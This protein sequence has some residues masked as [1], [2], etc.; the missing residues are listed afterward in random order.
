[1]S[2]YY[3]HNRVYF[4][5]AVLLCFT[6]CNGQVKTN[7]PAISL[8]SS[9]TIPI[10]Y[11]KPIKTHGSKQSDNIRCGLQDKAGNLWFGTTGD[12]VYR[13]DGKLFSNY[14]TKEGLSSNAV[15]S[16]IEDKTGNIW[17][18]TDA[19]L[20]SY[21]GKSFTSVPITSNN[22]FYPNNSLNSNASS[23]NQVWSILQDKSG[24]IWLGTEEGIYCFNGKTFSRFLDNPGVINKSG[25]T[26]KSIQCMLEDK[27][28][29]LWFGS[30]PIAFEGICLYDGKSL[31]NFKP[32]NEGW[33]RNMLEDKNGRLMFATRHIGVYAY[34]G[35]NFSNFSKP[36]ELR[37]DLLNTI[38]LDKERNIWYSSDYVNDN[39][40][41]I[42]GVWK[43]D[44][45]SFIKFTK[46][47]GIS[48]TSVS[49]MMEDRNGNIWLG[50]RNTGLYRYDGKTFTT[51]AE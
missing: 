24:I 8:S 20:S 10:G 50:T 38:L 17:F 41:T 4:L 33:I 27:N 30:G 45:K 40:F 7:T 11:P 28:G 34:D 37:N 22:N 15:W 5:L 39:D 26:L 19:G 25:L 42:G 49:F 9:T 51:F 48:N 16:V 29:N 6:S 43:F 2:K 1:V 21:D 46:A 18:G 32:K 44:G 3:L 36:Q 12:G 13:Y 23:K 31:T 47:D 14:T 35:K